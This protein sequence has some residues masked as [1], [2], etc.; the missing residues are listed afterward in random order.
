[1][2]S[3]SRRRKSAMDQL[4]ALDEAQW[5]LEVE[6]VSWRVTVENKLW[7]ACEIELDSR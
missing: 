7:S 2:S 1:M 3:A 5:L 4:R 6:E